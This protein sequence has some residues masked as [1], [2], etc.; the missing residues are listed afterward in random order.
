MKRILLVCHG[1]PFQSIGGVGQV[2]ERLLE[3][4]PQLGWQVHVLVPNTHRGLR[5]SYLEK[6]CYRWG[7]L[8][9]QHRFHIRWSTAWNHLPDGEQ[10]QQLIQ[11]EQIQYVHI[12]HLNGLSFHGWEQLKDCYLHVTLH[13]YALPC[14]R[15]QLFDRNW[16][17]CTGPTLEKCRRCVE[18]WL[19]L[20]STDS[21]L[22]NRFVLSQ[23]LLRNA[24]RIDAPSQDLITRIQQ[25]YPDL[26]VHHCHLPMKQCNQ[27][28]NS[29]DETLLFVGS[30]HPSK[31]IHI[32]LQAMH[33][34]RNTPFKLKIIGGI[35]QTDLD[36]L[37]A[38]T[39]LQLASDLP[40]VEY[41]GSLSHQDT[42]KEMSH[43]S[44]LIL[45][46]MWPENSPLVIREALQ[47]GLTIICG[48]G[49]SSELSESIVRLHPVS[50]HTICSA[51]KTT[52]NHHPD[53][54][55]YPNTIE[56]IRGWITTWKT[57]SD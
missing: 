38:D 40:N 55:S 13:D 22:L 44:H 33:R 43:V 46:S 28:Q 23:R 5:P 2:I 30:I 1:H 48:E 17:I 56:T 20:E 6:K 34:L 27:V 35:T 54:V 50:V 31:G 51:I 45:P 42:L 26:N 10:I 7:V 39:W 21:I 12:H 11:Q 32:L 29:N 4:L 47:R 57:D 16:Q 18:P 25:I 36:P 49:G 52:Q 53:L 37:Y 15:G 24:N 3:S 19:S 9:I 8:H 14:S 41:L